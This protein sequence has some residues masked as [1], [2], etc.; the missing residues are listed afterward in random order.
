ML[1]K[2]F[3]DA[4]KEEMIKAKQ[5]Y[6]KTCAETGDGRAEVSARIR[7]GLRCRA[8]L[9]KTFIDGAEK[10]A[11]FTEKSMMAIASG[12]EKPA[13]PSPSSFQTIKSVN[14]EIIAYIPFAFAEEVFKI[15]AAYQNEEVSAEQSIELCQ[16][17]AEKISEELK[18]EP[19]FQALGFMRE[20]MSEGAEGEGEPDGQPP[21]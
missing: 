5:D 21:S 17:I 15:G 6:E 19:P 20:D 18:L 11:D 13:P 1:G 9:D 10:T 12:D 2:L 3:G 7:M 14:G 16:V 8:V 4:K